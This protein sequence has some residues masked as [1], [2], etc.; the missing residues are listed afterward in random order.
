MYLPEDLLLNHIK[1]PPKINVNVFSPCFEGGPSAAEH[2]VSFAGPIGFAHHYF[3]RPISS[4]SVYG[5]TQQ[6]L[7]IDIPPLASV[8]N[9]DHMTQRLFG[10]HFSLLVNIFTHFIVWSMSFL[11]P[12][13]NTNL[14][15]RLPHPVVKFTVMF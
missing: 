1:I 15:T 14:A 11:M 8:D 2:P 9:G 5:H 10:C 3:C 6:Q 7:A 4:A 12:G 13:V